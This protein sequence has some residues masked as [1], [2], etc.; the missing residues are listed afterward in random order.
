MFLD[1]KIIYDWPFNWANIDYNKSVTKI[2]SSNRTCNSTEVTG[3]NLMRVKINAQIKNDQIKTENEVWV[4][5]RSD[6]C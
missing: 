6:K 4:I 5:A 2:I 3:M 1:I